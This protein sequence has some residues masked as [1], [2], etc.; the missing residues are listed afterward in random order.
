MFIP[1]LSFM[2][3]RMA[4]KFNYIKECA[5]LIKFQ[6]PAIKVTKNFAVTQERGVFGRTSVIIVD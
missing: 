6:E 1:L 3:I 4:L 5:I 2:L